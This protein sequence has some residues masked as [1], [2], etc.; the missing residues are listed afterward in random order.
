[1]SR[2]ILGLIPQQRKE[3]YRIKSLVEI[4]RK[5]ELLVVVGDVSAE[6]LV[7]SGV[8]L[9]ALRT[10]GIDFEFYLAV[11]PVDFSQLNNKVIGVEAYIQNCVGCLELAELR[12]KKHSQHVFHVV[13]DL[14]RELVTLSREEY[15]L[16]LSSALTKYTPRSLAS[17]LSQEV[18]ELVSNM[19]SSG[20]LREVVAPKLIGWG[21]MPLEDVVRY[22]VDTCVLKYFGKPVSKVTES[23]IAREL[24]VESLK[25]LEDRTYVPNYDAGI[26][27]LYEA[28]Y[29]IEYATDVEGPEYTA[30]MP[31]NYDYFLWAIRTFRESVESIRKCIDSFLEKRF[32]RE[33]PFYTIECDSEASGTVVT[34][35]LRGLKLIEENA[36]VVHRVAGEFYVPIQTLTR[37]QKIKLAGSRIEGGYAVVDSG[38]LA[39]IQRA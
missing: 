3:Q 13:L 8:I 27:D 21:S 18:Q 16:L 9:R 15:T 5:G 6:A 20:I 38:T 2:E 23:D 26:M 33:G 30:F 29:I 7:S 11:D 36:V 10:L 24:K 4:V 28:A 35:I 12:S 39:K 32:E 17:N 37:T 34:K 22:S 14:V 31:L 25:S 19:E 1:M